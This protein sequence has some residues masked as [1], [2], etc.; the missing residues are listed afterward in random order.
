MV[1]EAMVIAMIM[2][3]DIMAILM[4]TAPT[5]MVMEIPIMTRAA[6]TVDQGVAPVIGDKIEGQGDNL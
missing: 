3:T 4:A 2:T 5:T 6:I 1:M